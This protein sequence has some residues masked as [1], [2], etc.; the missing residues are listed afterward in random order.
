MKF[1]WED[2]CEQNFQE[3]KNHFIF[4]P[5]LTFPITRASYVVFSDVRQGLRCVLIQDGRVIAYTFRQLE[6]HEVNYPTHDLELA[7]VIFALKIWRHYLYE[8]TCQ[9]FTDHKSF[10][11][12]PKDS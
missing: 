9:V 12:L 7:A 3:L 4:A 6:K 8:K 2:K 11:Y 5:I 10:K 1:E